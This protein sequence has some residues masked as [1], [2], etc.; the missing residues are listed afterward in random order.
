MHFLH[1]EPLSAKSRIKPDHFGVD[2]AD[3]IYA[4][5]NPKWFEWSLPV[6]EALK[7]TGPCTIKTLFEHTRQTP[8]GLSNALAWLESQGA[9]EYRDKKWA[10]TGLPRPVRMDPTNLIQALADKYQ[11]TVDKILGPVT[12]GPCVLAR[13]EFF[14]ELVLSY[15]FGVR[16]LASRYGQTVDRV[17]RCIARWDMRRKRTVAPG[18]SNE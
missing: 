18:S 12:V 16:E 4:A 5:S 17:H 15:G 6:W 2:D 1:S 8:G 11:T 9:V 7:L 3:P 14:G 10:A 13:D